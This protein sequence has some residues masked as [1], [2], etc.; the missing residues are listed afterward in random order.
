MTAEQHAERITMALIVLCQSDE[1]VQAM[2]A[3]AKKDGFAMSISGVDLDVH[4]VGANKKHKTKPTITVSD[5]RFLRSLRIA[6][7]EPVKEA[8]NNGPAAN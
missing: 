4:A 5:R 6:V 1:R 8:T 2:V 3:E 7:D